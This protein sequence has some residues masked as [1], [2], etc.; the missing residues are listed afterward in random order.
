MIDWQRLTL[1]LRHHYKSLWTV[2]RELGL[3]GA[4]LNRLARGEI[5]EPRFN[6]GVKLLDLHYDVMGERHAEILIK[7]TGKAA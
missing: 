6:S 4:H 1:N 7:K 2:A 5:N 3:D